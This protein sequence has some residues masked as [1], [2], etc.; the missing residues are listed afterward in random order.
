MKD[1]EG[2]AIDVS[3]G[4]IYWTGPLAK[5]ERSN[6]DGSQRETLGSISGRDLALDVGQGKMY[7][8]G[9]WDRGIYR[10]GLGGAPIERIVSGVRPTAI[11][12][13]LSRGKIYWA[14]RDGVTR[15]NLDGTQV[16]KIVSGGGGSDGDVTD[17]DI[18]GDRGKIYW[19]HRNGIRRANL[20]G[21]QLEIFVDNWPGS[22]GIAIDV[23]AGKIYWTN[24]W[25]NDIHRANLDGSQ[26][27][28]V[29]N[30]L[31]NRSGNDPGDIALGP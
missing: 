18:D 7:F 14:E 6:L 20:D 16:E 25:D 31:N 27:E 24:A 12:L 19:V 10:T 28:R 22:G 9:S 26:R 21:T 17:I 3:G 15:A 11:T 29:V 8:A 13:D 2:I 23:G 1:P 5:T 30:D 4:K